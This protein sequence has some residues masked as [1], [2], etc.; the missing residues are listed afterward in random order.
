MRHRLAGSQSRRLVCLDLGDIGLI[1]ANSAVQFGQIEAGA[2][3]GLGQ[4]IAL[5]PGLG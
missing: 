3:T 2:G 4:M 1:V 5:I